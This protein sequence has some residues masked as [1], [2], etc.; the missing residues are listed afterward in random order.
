ME[1]SSYTGLDL[2]FFNYNPATANPPRTQRSAGNTLSCPSGAAPLGRSGTSAV[3]AASGDYIRY[4][5]TSRW[6]GRKAVLTFDKRQYRA[7]TAVNASILHCNYHSG[8]RASSPVSGF[9]LG[10]YADRNSRSG[11]FSMLAILRVGSISRLCLRGFA[12]CR[13][14][15]NIRQ[16]QGVRRTW[17]AGKRAMLVDTTTAATGGHTTR[18]RGI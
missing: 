9:K 14:G 3:I 6:A 5:R 17:D 12:T 7:R 11:W 1:Q 10:R 13:V 16:P 4:R 8:C 18:A 15:V 2:F